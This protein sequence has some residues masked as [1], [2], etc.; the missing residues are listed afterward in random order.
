L[1]KR[2]NNAEASEASAA[3]VG[4]EAQLWQMADALR[5]ALLSNLISGELR[6][7]DAERFLE[8]ARA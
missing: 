3:T 7:E 2:K 6:V 8:R 4:Y 1:A 5:D